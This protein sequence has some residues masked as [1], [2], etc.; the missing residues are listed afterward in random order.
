MERRIFAAPLLFAPGS[1]RRHSHAAF[2][3]LASLIERASGAS[4]GDYI[5]ARVFEPAG[6]RR[7]GFYGDRMGLNV[8]QFAV[9]GGPRFVGRPN[10]PPNWGPTSWLVMG[11]GGMVSTLADLERFDDFARE[12][13]N[14]SE[15][16]AWFT[17]SSAKSDG[18]DGGFDLHS[19]YNAITRAQFYL[20][21]NSQ[22]SREDGVALV[23]GLERWMTEGDG[24]LHGRAG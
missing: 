3:L 1:Q 16:A 13:G 7:T 5:R 17:H 11:S 20:L 8:D 4:Y 14:D 10:I 24:A 18:S 12:Q 6:M 15:L 9:G 21:F 19:G 22:P 2:G 23:R